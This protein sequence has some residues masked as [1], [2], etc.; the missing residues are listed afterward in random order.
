VLP[1]HIR[2]GVTLMCQKLDSLHCH[3]A[4]ESENTHQAYTCNGDYIKDLSS[5]YNPWTGSFVCRNPLTEYIT[6]CHFNNKTG[7]DG[8]ICYTAHTLSLREHNSLSVSTTCSSIPSSGVANYNI[9]SKNCSQ[10]FKSFI[11]ECIS[12]FKS[13]MCVLF[14]HV[15]KTLNQGDVAVIGV[16][17]I[18]PNLRDCD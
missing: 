7:L 14:N 9:I 18:V 4:V 17:S 16:A 6:F 1:E 5:Y 12:D 8:S 15:L 10:C 11:H 2:S 3:V 13:T